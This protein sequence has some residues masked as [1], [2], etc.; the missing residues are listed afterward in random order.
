MF[1]LARIEYGR[2][3]YGMLNGR[4]Q[5]WEINTN[6]T[7]W[8]GPGPALDESRLDAYKQMLSP[9][10]DRFY[11]DFSA[12]W[13]GL[14]DDRDR[15]E[16]IELNAPAPLRRAIARDAARR[17]RLVRRQERL[18]AVVRHPWVS[19]AARAIKRVLTAIEARRL[20]SS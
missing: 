20:R 18:D 5:L 12:A 9:G 15:T 4:P 10:Y 19:P 13:H 2:I 8:R 16:H 11:D 17:R 1:D 6:P 7:I 14:D 3:D